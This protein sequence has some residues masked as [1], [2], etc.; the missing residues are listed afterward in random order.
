MVD[1]VHLVVLKHGCRQLRIL[2][3]ETILKLFLKY[4]LLL[5]HGFAKALI[6][7]G[8]LGLHL[9]VSII[10]TI[11]V[12]LWLRLLFVTNW[13]RHPTTQT[14]DF[15]TVTLNHLINVVLLLVFNQVG[16]GVLHSFLD[17]APFLLNTC[18]LKFQV[19]NCLEEPKSI[20][21]GGRLRSLL[22]DPSTSSPASSLCVF[23]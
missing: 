2:L 8:T 12:T 23:C 15:F 6:R 11:W 20:I 13:F 22:S 21:I 14:E 16:N 3:Y 10:L 9:L 19:S 17:L 5:F 1:C 4:L 18:L 7:Q